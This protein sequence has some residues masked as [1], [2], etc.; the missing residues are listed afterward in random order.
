LE[1][2]DDHLRKD[3]QGALDNRHVADV[4]GVERPWKNG[5]RCVGFGHAEIVTPSQ[6]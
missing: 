4:E 2:A 3:P 6:V 5:K 1:H